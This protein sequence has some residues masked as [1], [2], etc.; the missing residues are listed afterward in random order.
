MKK[1]LTIV[2]ILL[3]RRIG[4]GIRGGR[5][6]RAGALPLRARLARTECLPVQYC[7]TDWPRLP[8]PAALQPA[9]P[10]TWA[11]SPKRRAT[12]AGRASPWSR[13]ARACRGRRRGS[14]RDA[15]ASTREAAG[16]G[17]V[18][19]RGGEAD[20]VARLEL[21][22]LRRACAR[23]TGVKRRRAAA[24]SST[25]LR[26]ASASARLE[27]AASKGGAVREQ[28]LWEGSRKAPREAP[29][30]GG[31]VRPEGGTTTV[32][33]RVSS[34]SSESSSESVCHEA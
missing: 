20:R 4:L 30:D 26:R 7:G 15:R 8:S 24:S 5:G 23:S 28:H 1:E 16:R 21:D 29:Q 27:L 25:V 6:R 9:Q 14:G 11:C 10:P 33:P 17:G 3:G 2:G 22:C 13:G 18:A 34:T 31:A 19:P 32:T 12:G